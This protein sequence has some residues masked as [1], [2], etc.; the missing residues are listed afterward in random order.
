LNG[1]KTLISRAAEAGLFVVFTRIDGKPGRE[2]IGCILVEAGAKGFA[3]TGN[4]HTMGG[5]NLHE[6][7][8][9][10]CEVPLENL[11]IREDGFRK[12]LTAF[13]TQ[14]C[15][16]PSIS[17]GLAEG[18][19]DEAVTYVRERELFGKPLSE[20]QGVRWKL[21][22]MYK[23]IEA[24]RG[25]LYRACATADPFPDPFLSA[26]AKVFCNEMSIRVTS[27]AVQLHGGYGFT[28]EYLV[29]RLYRG[30]RYGSLGGGA[31]ETLRDLIGRK[32]VTDLTRG[33][34]IMGLSDDLDAIGE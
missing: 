17:L 19:F 16:N 34:G 23:D 1:T 9:N 33:D 25:L 21:A 5:E 20:S 13:N 26:T 3:V 32:I 24:G 28:D 12:L 2:G 31:S 6:V 8:F 29:S 27:E 7:Q 11:V 4:Y 10:D 30:A 22:D 15:L 14:R 18:A